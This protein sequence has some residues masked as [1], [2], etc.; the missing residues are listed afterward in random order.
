LINV[1]GR[2]IYL[3]CH[4]EGSPT[5]ILQSGFGNAGDIWAA[6]EAKPPPVMPGTA[7]FTRVCAYDRP[8]STR[9]L[10]DKG[11]PG[12]EPLPA[13]SNPAPMPRTGSD[14]VTELHDL[15]AAASVPGPYVL[16]GHSLGGLFNL[17]Y[18]RTYPEQV[19]GLVMVDNTPPPLKRLMTSRQWQ[20][21][22]VDPVR[23]PVSPIEGYVLEAYDLDRLLQQIDDAAPPPRQTVVMLTA[24]EIQ[25]G[26]P[27]EVVAVFEPLL[28]K[29]RAEFA[30]SIPGAT[31][32][33]VPGTSH[34][35]QNQRPDVVIDTI[36]AVSSA[37][38]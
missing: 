29:A 15:L 8:G 24:P 2:N 31:S 22:V 37:D 34:H 26:A 12:D 13:R 11:V 10:D 19:S 33:S 18:A 27:G 36:R 4:G 7:T 30:A 5:V 28:P 6:T 14:V 23:R 25:P 17:L 35:I 9:V 1:N 32:K 21:L 38:R 16:T 20:E 3:E